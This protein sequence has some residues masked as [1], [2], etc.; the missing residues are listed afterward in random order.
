MS[1]LPSIPPTLS[2]VCITRDPGPQVAAVL[3]PLREVAH[4]IIVAADERVGPDDLAAY[5]AVADRVIRYAFALPVERPYAWAHAQ[6]T[7]SWV[8]RIDGDEWLSPEL[9][10]RLPH[11]IARPD[12]LQYWFTRRWSFPDAGHW[13]DERPWAPDPQLRLVRNDPATLSFPG[14]MHTAA[15]PTEPHE[16]I[17][18]PFYHAD[19]LLHPTERRRAKTQTY[20]A[21]RPGMTA[22]SG[23]SMEMY[24]LPERWAERPSAT[25]EAAHAEGVAELVAGAAQPAAPAPDFDPSTL[26]YASREEIDAHWDARPFAEEDAAATITPLER[27]VRFAPGEVGDLALRVRNDGARSWP[28][29]MLREPV[30]RLGHRWLTA[31]GEPLDHGT[32]RTGFTS[33]VRAG[34][35]VV[36]RLAVLA[37]DQ[38]GSYLVEVDVLQEDVRWF[39][40]P[41]RVPIEIRERRPTD[42]T[43]PP[44]SPAGRAPA[45][46]EPADVVAVYAQ[47]LGREPAPAE[48]EAQIESGATR[49]DLLIAVAA[50]EEA[51]AR[52]S[53]ADVGLK[54]QATA[55]FV[56]GLRLLNDTLASAGFADRYW[57]WA[58]LL[59]G[60]ARE[61]WPLAHD[62]A[63]ADFCI[64]REHY[65]A[66]EAAAL[67]LLAAGFSPKYRFFNNAGRVTEISFERAGAK[68]EFF[69]LDEIPGGELEYYDL[70]DGQS[71]GEPTEARARI[72]AQPLESIHFV[73]RTW[74]KHADHDAELTAMY[75]SW[76]TPDEDW[77][78]MDDR[79]IVERTAWDRAT[80]IDWDGTLGDLTPDG[81]RR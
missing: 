58:G 49:A 69:V 11:L 29:G 51:Q 5:A 14:L 47:L 59:I 63:D 80:E 21:L 62:A 78:F 20:E 55:S 13:L 15:L 44:M 39:G 46:M 33:G 35:S 25:A 3:G 34:E 79:A 73:G 7:G 1:P 41:V 17:E 32:P 70:S 10:A 27:A 56:E 61:G 67:A 77:W 2:V 31:E 26:A 18:E 9:I 37:P 28:G 6:C 4:E 40:G 43:A 24:Y 71:G 60:Y 16:I 22:P 66:F 75:G 48:I 23:G 68:F 19:L 45:A 57:I 52:Q 76:R 65:P 53:A 50:S 54:A 38:P 74:L 64:R 42:G 30:V 8:L 36:A 12:R 72:A 81:Y